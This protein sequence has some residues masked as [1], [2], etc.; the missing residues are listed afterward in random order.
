[1]KKHFIFLASAALVIAASCNKEEIKTA[2][3]TELITVQLN[4]E[5]KTSLGAEG[6]TTWTSGDAVDV[7]VDGN[8]VGT[9]TLVEG[10]TFSGEL[11]TVGLNGEAT[12]KYPAGVAAVPAEQEA[13]EGSFANG[14]ALLEGAVDLDVLRAGEGA[15]LVNKTALLQ[16]S[17]AVA[18]DV[19][20]TLGETTYTV[21]G[22]Q[23]ILCLRC[24]GSRSC[25]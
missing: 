10:S 8:N 12:L 3:E 9:L 22:C 13:V 2:G 18:G 24:S 5:T 15:T 7:I 19:V 14:A 4:P 1:M 25:A 20:F 21:T 6:T 16:F 11:T 17:V 23:D